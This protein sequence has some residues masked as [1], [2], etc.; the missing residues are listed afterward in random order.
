MRFW[1][2]S[3]KTAI[4]R[5]QKLRSTCHCLAGTLDIKKDIPR[6]RLRS[7]RGKAGKVL[8]KKSELDRWME[9][10]RI[11]SE[12]HLNLSKIADEALQAVLGNKKVRKKRI[13]TVE[14]VSGVNR[15]V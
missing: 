4:G 5:R 12:E 8:F 3:T 11:L 10:N 13:D 14:R 9:T 6:F 7:E 1:D 2:T 15:R